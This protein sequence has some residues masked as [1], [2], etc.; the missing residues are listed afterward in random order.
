MHF[1]T[2]HFLS[3]P[4]HLLYLFAFFSFLLLFSIKAQEVSLSPS[5]HSSSTLPQLLGFPSTHHVEM[6]AI[7]FREVT[8][9]VLDLFYPSHTIPYCI[10]CFPDRQFLDDTCVEVAY[11]QKVLLLHITQNLDLAWSHVALKSSFY[12][13][14]KIKVKKK[15]AKS[16]W[17]K[18]RLSIGLKYWHCSICFTHIQGKLACCLLQGTF[19]RNSLASETLFPKFILIPGVADWNLCCFSVSEFLQTLFLCTRYRNKESP[20]FFSSAVLAFWTPVF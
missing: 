2:L 18:L 13:G 9:S 16:I 5:S 20:N 17:S 12:C 1:F 8:H 19:N 7:Q 15:D 6:Y 3:N 4:T 14:Q 11:I 10:C